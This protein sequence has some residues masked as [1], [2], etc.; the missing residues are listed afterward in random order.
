MGADFAL[1]VPPEEAAE[2]VRFAAWHAGSVETVPKRLFI[3]P[4]G[5]EFSQSD[6]QLR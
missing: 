2:G 4:L 6:L 1:F 5:I 3:E